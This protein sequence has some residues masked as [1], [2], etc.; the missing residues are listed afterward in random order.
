MSHESACS[1]YSS[2]VYND[3]GKLYQSMTLATSLKPVSSNILLSLVRS[4]Y[5]SAHG[6]TNIYTEKWCKEPSSSS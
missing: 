5:K 4:A 3:L 1:I 6:N 2:V